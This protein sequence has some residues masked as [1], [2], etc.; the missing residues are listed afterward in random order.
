MIYINI[1]SFAGQ[2]IIR[3]PDGRLQLITVAQQ[4]SQAASSSSQSAATTT[5]LTA[6]RALQPPTAAIT[7]QSVLVSSSPSAAIATA[8][9]PA[10]SASTTSPASTPQTKVIIPSQAISSLPGLTSGA[11]AVVSSTPGVQGTGTIN[12]LSS[13]GQTVAKIISPTALKGEIC[14]C[15]L[16]AVY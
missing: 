13:G 5:P 12:V 3:L 10:T 2:Q 4:A 11:I 1:L 8:S 14:S 7:A 9:S 15:A 6:V 16:R